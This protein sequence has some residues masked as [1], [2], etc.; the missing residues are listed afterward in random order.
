MKSKLIFLREEGVS[1]AVDLKGSH[2]T[3]FMDQEYFEKFGTNISIFPL[4]IW[5]AL[6]FICYLK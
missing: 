2:E 6:I 3:P 4:K 1:L 5:N